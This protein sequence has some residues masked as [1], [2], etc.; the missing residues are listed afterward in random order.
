MCEAVGVTPASGAAHAIHP[1]EKRIY[2]EFDE[3]RRIGADSVLAL[4]WGEITSDYPLAFKALSQLFDRIIIVKVN[5]ELTLQHACL[6]LGRSPEHLRIFCCP[7]DNIGDVAGWKAEVCLREKAALMFDDNPDVVRA[8]H[9][10]CINA[11]CVS[12]RA[13]KFHAT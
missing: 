12:E 13:W 10:N 2:A 6:W 11:I 3:A 7:D 1:L 4:D 5:E 8:C 9:R